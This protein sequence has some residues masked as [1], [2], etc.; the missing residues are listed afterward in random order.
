MPEKPIPP[1]D[2]ESLVAIEQELRTALENR[3]GERVKHAFLGFLQEARSRIIA[4]AA[5]EYKQG[6]DEFEL[7]NHCGL[8]NSAVGAEVINHLHLPAMSF[9]VSGQVFGDREWDFHVVSIAKLSDDLWVAVDVSTASTPEEASLFGNIREL[10]SALAER[11]GGVW[12]L[13]LPNAS[14]P[15]LSAAHKIETAQGMIDAQVPAS[16]QDFFS[17][18]ESSLGLTLVLEEPER[19]E[20]V[21]QFPKLATRFMIQGVI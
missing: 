6:A 4:R 5:S 9:R 20:Q 16:L 19:L 15:S 7:H 21:K 3:D 17:K 10:E 8:V 12:P 18:F 1:Q 11:F 14:N 2:E 13:S